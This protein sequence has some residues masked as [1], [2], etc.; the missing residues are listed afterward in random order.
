MD[1]V[2]RYRKTIRDRISEFAKFQPAR[3][4]VQIETIF[5]EGNDQYD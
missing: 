2:M 5:D 3:G 1:D 4:D